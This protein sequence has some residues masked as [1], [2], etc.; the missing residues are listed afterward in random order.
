M[1]SPPVDLPR[2][3]PALTALLLA[4]DARGLGGA[5]LDHPLHEQARAFSLLVQ[6]ALPDGAPL[7]RVPSSVTPDRLYGGVDL[8]ATLSTGKLVAERGVLAAAD[9][10]VIVV[11]M[12]E[13]L[14]IAARTALC[15]VLDHAEVQVARDG[16]GERHAARICALVMDESI[17]D[18]AVHAALRDRLAFV[19]RLSGAAADALLDE[20]DERD[21]AS[22]ERQ[23]RDAR[24]RLT[25]VSVDESW[26]AALCDTAD[27]FGIDSVRAPLMALRCARAHA[28]LHGRLMIVEADAEVAAALV[29]APR[30]T[31]WPSPPPEVANENEPPAS[32]QPP[33]PEPPEPPA[34]E[35]K[36]DDARDEPESPDADADDERPIT[37][38]SSTDLLR[39]AVAS[40]LP[41]GMLA[42]LLEK[43]SGGTMHGRVGAEKQ[44]MLRGRPRGARSGSPR[45]GARLHLLETL[46]AAA[47]WQRARLAHAAQ[48]TT[49]ASA[50]SAA[51]T[52]TRPRV[53]IRREDFR[54]RRYIEKTGTTV[55]FVVDA[56]GSSALHRLAEA[57]GAVE[58]LLAESYARRDRVSLIAFRGKGTELLLPPTRALARAKKVLA[59][60]PGGGGTPLA[61]AIEA[62]LEQAL[63]VK[64]SG[65]APLVVMLT[66]GRANIARDGAPGRPGAERDA[67]IASARFAQQNIPALFVD[68]SLRGEPVARRVADAMRARYVLL[69]SANAKALGGLVRT[70]MQM[71]DGSVRA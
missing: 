63:A 19:V 44:N 27:A 57:K 21:V 58:M 45:G 68:T 42:Q 31:R 52:H 18:E 30:A 61:H 24:H 32:A 12:A 1:S 2:G 3:G 47:P 17:D 29:L 38:S 60:L 65:S 15:E 33:S 39:E 5:M 62:A 10:G 55:L 20:T 67:L 51:P 69:P 40:A 35:L 43:V 46:R 50:P 36:P 59:A 54:I 70:A 23:A 22:W 66:D 28:A 26:I 56:S 34:M 7:R 64:R 49:A 4:V 6:R 16:I 9:G 25:S 14:S 37:P 53:N 41:P 48:M 8:A 11:P 13:R 71:A